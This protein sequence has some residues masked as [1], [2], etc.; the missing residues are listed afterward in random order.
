M[1]QFCEIETQFKDLKE[2]SAALEQMQPDWKLEI[3]EMGLPLMGYRGDNRSILEKSDPNYAPLCQ[4]KISKKCVGTS[5]N[6][7]GFCQNADGTISAYISDYDKNHYNKTW[8]NK[9]KQSYNE[10]VLCKMA[11]SQ[12]AVVKK[13]VLQNGIVRLKLTY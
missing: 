1:S 10:K 8:L 5:S 9:L 3:T 12:R 6:D 2:L 4:I 13:Q 7:I 11:L